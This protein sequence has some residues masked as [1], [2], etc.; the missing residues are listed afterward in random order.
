MTEVSSTAVDIG[1][2]RLPGSIGAECPEQWKRRVDDL[3]AWRSWSTM[4][5]DYGREH[6]PG[7]RI[8]VGGR[9]VEAL[10]GD[11]TAFSARVA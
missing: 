10:R 2:S 11:I 8:Q 3:A 9:P 4:R 5:H 6:C 1:I 7:E